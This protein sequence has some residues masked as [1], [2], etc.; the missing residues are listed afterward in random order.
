MRHAEAYVDYS[1]RKQ[2]VWQKLPWAKI[3]FSQISKHIAVLF[4]DYGRAPPLRWLQMEMKNYSKK[5]LLHN[6]Y[7]LICQMEK[8]KWLK[9][10]SD[11][12][13]C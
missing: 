12:Q 10:Y 13:K 8:K 11:V 3:I 2:I 6:I 7:S 9:I 4:K 1:W 5:I